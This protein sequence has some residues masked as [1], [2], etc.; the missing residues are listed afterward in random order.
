MNCICLIQKDLYRY[1]GK[2]DIRTLIKSYITIPG[3][4]YMFFLRLSRHFKDRNDCLNKI[5]YCVLRLIVAHYRVKFGFDIPESTNIGAG[6]YI[7]H[8]GGIVIN[9]RTSIGRNVNIAS[10][11]VIGQVS[12]GEK[13]GYPTIEDN[14]WIGSHAIIVGNI[15]IATNA[16]IAPG[17]YVNFNVPENAVVI[18]NPGKIVS[19]KGSHGYVCNG[20]DLSEC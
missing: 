5:L 10:G 15:T 9:Y 18:G 6:F 7:G 16:L 19:Y 4:R 2:D 3:F 17:A 12:R 13:K 8:F 11:V 14:V 1:H 20:I